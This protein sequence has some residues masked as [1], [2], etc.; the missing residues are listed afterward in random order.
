M[1]SEKVIPAATEHRPAG[2]WRRGARPI[3]ATGS[4]LPTNS[5]D[6]RR[7]TG[8]A[9]I[10]AVVLLA[11]LAI[12]LFAPA[13]LAG[14]VVAVAVLLVAE[15]LVRRRGR[16]ALD[17]LLVGLAGIGCALILL[18]LLLNLLP[19]GLTKLSWTVGVAVTGLA[20]LLPTARD[21]LP[22]NPFATKLRQISDTTWI[23]SAAAVVVLGAAVA[24]SARVVHQDEV[25]PLQ[26]ASTT[27]APGQV[28][29]TVSSGTA[30]SGLS[31][32]THTGAA[33][34]VTASGLTVGPGRSATVA[35][36]TPA[37]RR[38]LVD[39]VDRS[40]TTIRELILDPADTRSGP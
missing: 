26:I 37:S 21:P 24:L 29:L 28:R 8:D 20:A 10:R 7:S 22:S 17:A 31:V 11:A 3:G 2:L 33:R 16:G 18:G 5:A 34:S 23:F 27:T 9:L 4:A 25:A 19:G 13:W 39:L 35:L 1:P 6:G 12:S 15:R 32:V 14:P 30:E 36:S 40:G 38:V